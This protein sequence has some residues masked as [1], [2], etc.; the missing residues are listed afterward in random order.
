MTRKYEPKASIAEN[1]V[2]G[3]CWAT[4]LSK[5]AKK[6]RTT[7]NIYIY[8]KTGEKRLQDQE[9]EKDGQSQDVEKLKGT[10]K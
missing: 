2:A 9:R 5:N 4:S 6:E 3:V 1:N 8:I 10:L 7:I